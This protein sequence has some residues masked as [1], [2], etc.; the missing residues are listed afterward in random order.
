M[1]TAICGVR[2][3]KGDPRNVQRTVGQLLTPALPTAAL[4]S[5]EAR[6][7]VYN[8]MNGMNTTHVCE[9]ER[10]GSTTLRLIVLQNWAW[11][12]STL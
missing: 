3:A 7:S 1:L 12:P 9:S 10:S 4:T 11:S 6:M 5:L 2:T 8:N